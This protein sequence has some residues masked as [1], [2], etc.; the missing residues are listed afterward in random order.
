MNFKYPRA[1][2]KAVSALL[3][4]LVLCSVLSSCGRHFG[5][6]VVLWT[7]DEGPIPAGSI[8]NIQIKSNIDKAYV[9]SSLDGKKNL[10]VPFWQLEVF[11]TKR[12]ARDYVAKLGDNTSLYLIAGRDGLPVRKAPKGAADRVFRLRNGEPVK[13]LEKAADGEKVETGG[14]VLGGD[15][16]LVLTND[17]TRGYVFSNTMKLFDESKGIPL[18]LAIDAATKQDVSPIN[19]DFFFTHTW[20][21]DYYQTMIDNKR[22]DLDRFSAR[23]GLFADTVRKQVRIE[24]PEASE[25]FNY[26]KI[27]REGGSYAFVGTPLRVSFTDQSHAY[28]DWSGSIV[29]DAEDGNPGQTDADEQAA[30]AAEEAARANDQAR[31]DEAARFSSEMDRNAVSSAAAAGQTASDSAGSTQSGSADEVKQAAFIVTADDIRQIITD[32]GLREERLLSDLIET[33]SHWRLESGAALDFM[34][35]GRFSMSNAGSFPHGY[36]PPAFD[37][38]AAVS[39]ELSSRLYLSAALAGTWKG[40]FSIR[41]SLDKTGTWA[42]FVYRS[43]GGDLVIAKVGTVS[44]LEVESLGPESVLRLSPR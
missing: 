42:H 19:I 7:V 29:I 28:A 15:W 26:R 36:L 6:G 14:E 11:T 39:G 3:A 20:R 17:G 40:S 23:Y 30:K 18:A 41:S 10:E 5:W 16:Y 37:G 43:E 25:V 33:G 27:Q 8:V 32:E 21:P 44:N 4:A 9:I 13:I 1:G 35:N 22:I 31:L 34:A 24:L 2:H 38:S 12:H